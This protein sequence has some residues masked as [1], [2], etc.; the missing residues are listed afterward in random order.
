MRV[1]WRLRIHIRDEVTDYYTVRENYIE[2]R[3]GGYRDVA[4]LGYWRVPD[5]V[6]GPILGP[7]VW[8]GIQGTDT[9]YLPK[10]GKFELNADVVA[11]QV[12]SLRGIEDLD[13]RISEVRNQ[14]RQR[15]ILFGKRLPKAAQE[16]LESLEAARNS[17]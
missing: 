16:L 5:I 12:E 15:K 4:R 11:A 9:D 17:D 10:V 1:T 8:E 13:I 2:N 6:L 3:V 14:M 7:D